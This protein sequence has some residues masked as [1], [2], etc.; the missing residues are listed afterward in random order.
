MT[1]LAT[2]L[3]F[4]LIPVALFK[5]IFWGTTDAISAIYYKMHTKK[6]ESIA[7]SKYTRTDNKDQTKNLGHR[8]TWGHMAPYVRL[9]RQFRGL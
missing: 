3:S 4:R 2:N 8:P 7:K 1:S 5:M 6:T 9:G